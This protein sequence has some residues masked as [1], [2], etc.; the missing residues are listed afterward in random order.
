MTA[1]NVVGL[2]KS[3]G[4]AVALDGLNLH[5]IE[6]EGFQRIGQVGRETILARRQ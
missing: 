1:L 2:R 6:A 4:G 3:Y 5:V